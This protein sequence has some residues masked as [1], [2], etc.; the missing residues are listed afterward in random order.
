MIGLQDKKL[1]ELKEMEME[2][3]CEETV[4]ENGN[5]WLRNKEN[6]LLLSNANEVGSER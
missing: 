3:E 1:S 5:K 2:E 4:V 6:P